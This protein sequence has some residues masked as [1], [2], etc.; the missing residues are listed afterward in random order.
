[1]SLA[2]RRRTT[3]LLAGLCVLLL[4]AAAFAQGWPAKP[5]RIVVPYPPGGGND[6][7][8][9]LIAPNLSAR[10]GQTVV[11]DN[12]AGAAG[13]LGADEVARSVADGHT[14]LMATSTI[15]M[16]P[17]LGQKVAYD[18]ERDLIAVSPVASTAMVIAVH[19]EV[20]AKNL[21]DLIALAKAQPGKFAYSTCGNASPMHLAGELL[22]LSA[23]IDLLHVPYKGCVPALTDVLGGQVA[24]AFNTISNTAAHERAGKIRIL[25]VA[26]ARRLADFPA[27]PS[28][29]EQGVAGYEAGIWFGL[30]APAQTPRAVIDAVSA[31]VNQAL[32]VPDVREKMRTAYYEPWAAG[33]GEFQRFVKDETTKWTRTIRAANIKAD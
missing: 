25:A 13:N 27:I 8:A 20:P 4:A 12:R 22:K 26:S 1:M 14:L 11:V 5:V 30:F 19:P 16:T 33:P 23:T 15:S 7:L 29:V 28:A 10:W 21:G 2:P 31:A 6:V 9:R 3:R 32:A 18:L 17:G 24:I